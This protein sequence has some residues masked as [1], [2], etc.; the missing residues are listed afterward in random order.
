MSKKKLT[1]LG[2][3]GIPARHGGFETFAERLALHL[4]QRGW[5]V[6]VFCQSEAG[7]DA[8][9]TWSGVTLRQVPVSRSGPLGSMI[10]DW[11]SIASGLTRDRVYLTL[12]YNTAAF[13]LA[14]ALAGRVNLFNMDG[15]EWTR[16]KWPLPIKAWFFL[17]ERLAALQASHL[18]ADH[19]AIA[20]R[21]TGFVS[22]DRVTMIPYG[23]DT[24]A[25]AD[26]RVLA[27]FGLQPHGYATIIARPEPEN[28]ILELVQAY[29]CRRRAE[30]LV[31]LG[32]YGR[33]RYEEAVRR[34][35]SEDVLFLGPIY[36]AETVRTLRFFCRFYCHGHQVGGTNPS[37]VEA[38]GAGNAVLAHN[39]RFNAWVAGEGAVYFDGPGCAAAMDNMLAASPEMLDAMRRASQARHAQLFTWERVLAHYER[40]L[41]AWIPEEPR[42]RAAGRRGQPAGP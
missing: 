28:S 37:L 29:S 25:D 17:N 16:S 6:E 33:G 40:L 19:P 8:A 21:L 23:A 18:I 5:D 26:A 42:R 13:S 10:F 1:I 11:K 39:N 38:L 12:G 35:A 15:L 2:I 4:V 34:A 7:A 32:S 22:P 31:V 24:I 30:K 14:H 27:R 9:P 36:E 3:R 20:Q 41:E